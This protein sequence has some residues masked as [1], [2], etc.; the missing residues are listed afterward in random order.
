MINW[1]QSEKKSLLLIKRHCLKHEKSSHRLEKIFA[2]A[3]STKAR[4]C[5][6]HL[7]LNSKD[8][9]HK[10]WQKS[11]TDISLNKNNGSRQMAKLLTV[12][13]RKMINNQENMIFQI[14]IWF[15]CLI[16]ILTN[17]GL[18]LCIYLILGLSRF[19]NALTFSNTPPLIVVWRELDVNEDKSIQKGIFFR[20]ICKG[21]SR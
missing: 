21:G 8:K 12:L 9:L 16:L 10:N 20:N 15:L 18:K 11:G 5:K 6:Q 7:Q 4:T 19:S 14:G 1:S 3:Y 17:C 2:N 13:I